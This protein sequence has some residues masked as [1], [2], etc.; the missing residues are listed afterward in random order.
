MPCAR[1]C[2]ASSGSDMHAFAALNPDPLYP[3]KES[4]RHANK[5]EAWGTGSL[6]WLGRKW[7]EPL[8]RTRRI[9]SRVRRETAALGDIDLAGVRRRA[10]DIAFDLRANG[11]TQESAARAFA[12]IRQAGR[13]ALGKAHFD[14]QLLGGWAML[15]G[16]V[17]EMHTGEG[18]TLTATLPAATVAM[19][20]LPVHVITTNDYLVER[21]AQI[22][23][24]IYEALGLAVARTWSIV[25]T[26]RWCLTTCAT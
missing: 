24:P 7:R 6:R 14:V 21:D 13:L 8:W 19:A 17:A 9:L 4:E 16:M 3:E 2:C 25:P 20:G 26:R 11:I 23:G 18:K 5:L 10:D 15:Q 1:W 12:L 22:M